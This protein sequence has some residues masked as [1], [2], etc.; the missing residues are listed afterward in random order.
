M[1]TEMYIHAFL[2]IYVYICIDIYIYVYMYMHIKNIY[3]YIYVY[4]ERDM[5]IVT[6][7]FAASSRGRQAPL[8]RSWAG[9]MSELHPGSRYLGNC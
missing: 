7:S 9:F 2:S 3:I 4:I 5:C 6:I 8:T 1:Q